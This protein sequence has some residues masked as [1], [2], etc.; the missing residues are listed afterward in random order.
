MKVTEPP[1]QQ[2]KKKGVVAFT[3]EFDKAFR[4]DYQEEEKKVEEAPVAVV[5]KHVVEKVVEVLEKSG[6]E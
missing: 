1:K 4:A 6:K 2:L 3:N 5:E